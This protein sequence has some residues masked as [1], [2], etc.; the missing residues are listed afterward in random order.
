MKFVYVF[1]A[2]VTPAICL[3]QTST[4]PKPEKQI[5]FARET[6][7]HTYYVQQAEL[8]WKEV[9]KDSTSETNWYNYFRACRNAWGSDDWKSDFIKESPYLKTGDDIVKLIYAHIPDSFTYYYLSYLNGGFGKENGENILKAYRMN[10][11][12][13]GIHSSVVSYA[14][15][16]FKDSLR[17]EVNKAWYKTNYFSPSLLSY[18]IMS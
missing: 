12:F 17:K 13:E 15:S 7:P 14:A 3:A 10:P 11:N 5:S 1:L 9:Q 8:W 2:L 4:N 6:K 18:T 16:N